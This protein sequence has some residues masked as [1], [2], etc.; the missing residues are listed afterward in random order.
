MLIA[1]LPAGYL[2]TYRL[3]HTLPV[4]T[5]NRP[6][7]WGAGLIGSIAPDV[8]LL[9]KFFPGIHAVN[10]HYYWTHYPLIWLLFIAASLPGIRK[11]PPPKLSALML[12]T[13][14]VNGLC[15]MILDSLAGGIAWGAPFSLNLYTFFPVSARYTPW[16]L[17]F[18]LPPTFLCEIAICLTAFRHF[19]KKW[20]LR[21]QT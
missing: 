16:W 8:D 19:Q 18:I 20:I 9:W 11:N 7:L 17:N 21:S 14:G 12:F 13:F 10:H 1:H 15:H 6:A 2:V 5:S 3:I 4:Q